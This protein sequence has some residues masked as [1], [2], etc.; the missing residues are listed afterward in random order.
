MAANDKSKATQT[1][2]CSNQGD[3]C[4]LVARVG[5]VFSPMAR[6]FFLRQCGNPWN[7]P[8]VLAGRARLAPRYTF[9]EQSQ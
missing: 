6:H 7:V 4:R 3:G 5:I 9:L 8:G 1:A 2:H